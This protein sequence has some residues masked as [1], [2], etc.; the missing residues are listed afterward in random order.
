MTAFSDV[1]TVVLLTPSR[2]RP[3]RRLTGLIAYQLT[4]IA[5]GLIGALCVLALITLPA[6]PFIVTL[7]A[8]VERRRCVLLGY[9]ALPAPPRRAP[10]D[11]LWGWLCR[12]STDP[13]T[14]RVTFCFVFSVLFGLVQLALVLF[15]LAVAMFATLLPSQVDRYQQEVAAGV[16]R[17]WAPSEPIPLP[18]LDH[19]KVGDSTGMVFWI[20]VSVLVVVLGWYLARV[21][22]HAQVQLTRFLLSTREAELKRVVAELEGSR[23]TL[24]D[25]FESD[26]VRIERDLHDGAQQHLVLTALLVGAA[27][28]QVRALEADVD[29]CAVTATLE[30]AQSSIELALSTLRRTILGLYTDVLSDHGLTAAI[31][32][33]AQRSVIPLSVRS[34]LTRRYPSTL[35]RCAYFTVSEAVT[36][37]LKHSGA[38]QI[39]VSLTTEADRLVVCVIDN[40]AGGVD[41]AQGTGVRGLRERA[42]SMGGTLTALSPSGGPTTITLELPTGGTS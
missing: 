8:T 28:K 36:N 31:E 16:N 10:F 32:E 33:L 34:K 7:F 41:L 29:I 22:A 21:L 39:E 25:S 2:R 18:G 13:A 11:S 19:I 4:S 20:V 6:L 3:F 5:L 17:P 30:K 14:W 37:A 35:E 40:G 1:D 15:C 38:S 42:R 27:A 24:I 9:P 12:V 26:R 23:S